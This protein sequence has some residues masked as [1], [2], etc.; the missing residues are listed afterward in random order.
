MP[1]R[2][3]APPSRIALLFPFEVDDERDAP[4]REG[5]AQSILQEVPVAAG[6][7]GPGIDHDLE[8]WGRIL[9]LHRIEQLEGL[10]SLLGWILTISHLFQPAVEVS[11]EDAGGISI[12]AV[13]SER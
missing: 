6:D 7:E 1:P 2:S 4:K 3:E 12:V 10:P 11:R 8:T 9:V 5:V 13:E